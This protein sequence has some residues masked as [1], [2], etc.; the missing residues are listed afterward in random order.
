MT[1]LRVVVVEDEAAARRLLANL[2]SAH[3]DVRVVGQCRNGV[4]AVATIGALQPDLVFLDIKLPELDGFGVIERIGVD[5]MPPVVFVTAYDRF[6]V[7]AFDVHALD[8]LV[9]P[10][11]DERFEATLQRAR[12]RLGETQ[13][14]RLRAALDDDR[15]PLARFSVRLG[16]RSTMIA[17][18][19]VAWIEA[20]DYC[21]VLHV[22]SAA[23]MVRQ[24]IRALEERLDPRRFVR[25]NRSAIV[26]LDHV[27]VLDRRPVGNWTITLA[28]GIV[29]QVSRRRRSTIARRLGER[30]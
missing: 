8:Y 12:R 2:L 25:I 13:A 28:H 22:G 14:A 1:E 5:R 10:F 15:G 29:L 24:S 23:H 6:A 11:S 3:D 21:V 20:E 4:Q 16:M 17:A 27:R 9:K 7:R 19:D 26:N 18:R 30:G